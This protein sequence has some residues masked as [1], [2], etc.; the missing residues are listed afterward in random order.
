MIKTTD[1]WVW[2]YNLE[3]EQLDTLTKG[4]WL[5]YASLDHLASVFQSV[6]VLVERG[7][8]YM[9]K[10]SHKQNLYLDPFP[11]SEPVMCVYADD[12]TKADVRL[13]L[14]N[15]GVMPDRW[16]YESETK[17]DLSEDGELRRKSD[18]ERM[19]WGFEGL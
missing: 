7:A 18:L 13:E 15:L 19:I 11:L 4:K 10:Y 1:V 2:S 6:D 8:I 17:D 16:K 12:R 9:A 3:N 14:L 5:V